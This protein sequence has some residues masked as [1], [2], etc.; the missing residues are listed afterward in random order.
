MRLG[1]RAGLKPAERLREVFGD[2]ILDLCRQNEKVVILDGDLSSTT[3]THAVRDEFPDRFFNIGI[4]ESNMVS[5]GAG[6][7]SCDLIPFMTSLSSFIL[8]NGFDQLRISVAL[9][10]INAKVVGSHGGITLGKDGPTAMAIEDLALVALGA[11]NG[12]E[13]GQPV[14]REQRGQRIRIAS[15]G[16]E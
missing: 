1:E 4:A 9:A 16:D 13:R 6:M 7:A 14:V 3:R 8:S 10:G 15:V 12:R 5:M 11:Q 2:A